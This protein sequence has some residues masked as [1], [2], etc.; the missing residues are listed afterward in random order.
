MG[1]EAQTKI[2]TTEINE[3]EV[4]F[5]PKCASN[6]TLPARIINLNYLIGDKKKPYAYATKLDKSF[7]N[8]FY[9]IDISLTTIRKALVNG[10][11]LSEVEHIIKV[12][13]ACA[14]SSFDRI[15]WWIAAGNGKYIIINLKIR[16]DQSIKII[17]SYYI[18]EGEEKEKQRAEKKAKV[19]K[20]KESYNLEF[21]N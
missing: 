13:N 17:D 11:K 15:E 18:H 20:A 14:F 3:I 1:L 4:I 2:S 9:A 21:E 6:T 16:Y 8:I 10:R 7:I 12:P 19:K 5:K